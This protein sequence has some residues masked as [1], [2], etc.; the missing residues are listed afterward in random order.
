MTVGVGEDGVPFG[1]P[2]TRP[3]IIC[4]GGSVGSNEGE[5]AKHDSGNLSISRICPIIGDAY[6]RWFHERTK[7]AGRQRKAERRGASRLDEGFRKKE[8]ARKL[9]QYDVAVMKEEIKNLKM[10]SSSTVC[11][12][13]SIGVGFG[14][15]T[16]ARPPLLASRYHEI[17]FLDT[18]YTKSSLLAITD[19]EVMLVVSDLEKMVP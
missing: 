10:G 11:G 19:D 6:A 5:A 18:D 12:E 2:N 9:I 7:E 13:A 15:D 8:R 14:S 3:R 4:D 1:S 17:S 16:S